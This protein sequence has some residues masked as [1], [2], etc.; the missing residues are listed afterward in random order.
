MPFSRYELTYPSKGLPRE[1]SSYLWIAIY[2]LKWHENDTY[3][4]HHFY[5]KNA[6]LIVHRLHYF[7]LTHLSLRA[8]SN[9]TDAN[10]VSYETMLL[11]IRLPVIT[12]WWVEW[13]CSKN[14]ILVGGIFMFFPRIIQN[15]VA[16][17]VTINSWWL[18]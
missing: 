9:K 13:A 18:G 16:E 3:F 5:L 15:V 8:K 4:Q 7:C 12:L 10:E 6:N 17:S 2:D 14:V 11:C 1:V